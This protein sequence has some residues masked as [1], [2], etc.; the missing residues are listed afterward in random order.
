M[1]L[2]VAFDFDYTM[3]DCNSDSHFVELIGDEQIQQY[4]YHSYVNNTFPT[5]TKL[6]ENVLEKLILEKN[7][8]VEDVRLAVRKSPFPHQMVTLLKTL[9]EKY[10]AKIV[11]ISD[12]NDWMIQQILDANNVSHLVDEIY[13]HRC[14]VYANETHL[15]QMFKLE[16]Y[17]DKHDCQ[18][19][20]MKNIC[21]GDIMKQLMSQGGY[22]RVWYVGD[23]KN[24]YCA[25]VQ[26]RPGNQDC[27]FIREGHEFQKLLESLDKS[28]IKSKVV[29]WNTYDQLLQRMFPIQQSNL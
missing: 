10:N 27:V 16:H 2:L 29:Y 12:A 15:K 7:K 8:S 24:D 23:G 17:I 18:Y 11:I 22:E 6:V 14:S 26:L 4:M 25:A 13:T 21:K 28:D 3:T 1:S 20:C 5:W 9:K 19:Y